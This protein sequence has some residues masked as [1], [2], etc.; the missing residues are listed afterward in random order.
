MQI[1]G[2]S[3]LDCGA[4]VEWHVCR[5]KW[6]GAS[7]WQILT[8]GT[9][10]VEE[11]RLE[12]TDW[13]GLVAAVIDPELELSSANRLACELG[14]VRDTRTGMRHKKTAYLINLHC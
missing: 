2:G 9:W 8:N 1:S 4:G 7:S 11:C 12:R 10:V 14:Q 3:T 6:L 13:E 5:E